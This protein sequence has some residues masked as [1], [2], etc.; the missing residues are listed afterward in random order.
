MRVE[1][2]RWFLQTSL[3][4]IMIGI[5]LL[6]HFLLFAGPEWMHI[7]V[8]RASRFSND[9]VARSVLVLFLVT[10]VGILLLVIHN[11]RGCIQIKLSRERN[12]WLVVFILLAL[13]R[14]AYLHYPIEALMLLIGVA[15]GKTCLAAC[16]FQVGEINVSVVSFLAVLMCSVA[17]TA[18]W[19]TNTYL[20]REF[21]YHGIVRWSG[22]YGSPNPFG[23][24][25]GIG[26]ILAVGG[27]LT[28]VAFVE[29]RL[30]NIEGARRF[31]GAGIFFLVIVLCG[32]GLWRS[33][34]RGAWLGTMVGLGYLVYQ[35]IRQKRKA[36]IEKAG[37]QFK[38]LL[39]IAVILISVLLLAFWQFRFSEWRSIQR[40]VSVTNPNDFSWRNRVTAWGGAIRMMADKPLLGFGWGKAEAAYEK[41]YCPQG[42]DKSAAIQMNDYF[43]L[44]ISAGVPV[45]ICFLMYI[46]MT[47]KS[48]AE[49]GKRKAEMDQPL[50]WIQTTCRAGAIVLLVGFFFD[51][52][53]FKLSVG[54]IFWMLMELSRIRSAEYG[55]RNDQMQNAEDGTC[56]RPVPAQQERKAESENLAETPHAASCVD[57]NLKPAR[58][59]SKVDIWLRRGAWTLG[60]IAFLQT[61]VYLSTP[62]FPIGK[63]TLAIA[64]KC[65]IPPKEVSDF[66]FLATNVDWHGKG[67]RILLQHANLA[68]YN[69]QLI[70]W[71]L[72]NEIYREYV[73]TPT[74]QPQCDGN[75]YWRRALWENFYPRMRH[76]TDPASAAHVVLQELRS[77]LTIIPDADEGAGAPHEK[78]PQTIEVIW[79]QKRADTAGFET[80]SVAVLRSVGVPARLNKLGKAEFF[81]GKTWQL[82]TL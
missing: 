14:N 64:R 50:D 18:L 32:C 56:F 72:D 11:V 40:I 49:N 52:G 4:A 48:K 70:N 31:I 54:P 2:I 71:K 55:I 12:V 60:T 65:L 69:R 82:A 24:L 45:L 8:K 10:Y 25:M 19:Q 44:G 38:N 51:G 59:R 27:I 22:V 23:L 20:W 67:L 41:D 36:E 81:N 43:M 57:Q 74:I 26:F 77:R 46:W 58:C 73:L 17:S 66:N 53:L 15:F 16:R 7:C 39:P 80:I 76:E 62:F 35:V 1:R 34:S 47:L 29:Q 33:Y 37:I 61:V 30:L 78:V 9:P 5:I 21:S 79:Q 75:L 6:S 13:L 28:C 42:L 68:N 63:T 3:C